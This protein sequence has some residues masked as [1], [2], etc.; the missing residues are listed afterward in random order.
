MHRKLGA[1]NCGEPNMVMCISPHYVQWLILTCEKFSNELKGYQM[2][3]Q[4]GVKPSL[5]DGS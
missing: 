2:H 1:S 5:N 4:V 3:S